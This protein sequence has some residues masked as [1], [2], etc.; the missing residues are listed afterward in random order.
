ME[1]ETACKINLQHI[2]MRLKH[3]CWKPDI[4]VKYS[5]EPHL[6]LAGICLQRCAHTQRKDPQVILGGQRFNHSLSQEETIYSGCRCWTLASVLAGTAWLGRRKVFWGTSCLGGVVELPS[7]WCHKHL[8]SDR[9]LNAMGKREQAS[10]QRHLMKGW[11]DGLST[12]HLGAFLAGKRVLKYTSRLPNVWHQSTYCN[13][14]QVYCTP[15]ITW[16]SSGN[17]SYESLGWKFSSVARHW[18]TNRRNGKT[19]S[20]VL[21]KLVGKFSIRI[22]LQWKMPFSLTQQFL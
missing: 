4:R 22:I 14:S 12:Q 19:M 20:R 13:K 10:R 1:N 3:W 15:R 21:I 2:A 9:Y 17:D 7:D 5:K 18:Y 11:G 8:E 16:W 6:G